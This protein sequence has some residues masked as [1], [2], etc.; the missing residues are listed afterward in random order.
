MPTPLSLFK[1]PRSQCRSCGW[2]GVTAARKRIG[3]FGWTYIVLALLVVPAGVYGVVDLNKIF[4]S[5]VVITIL[6]AL[7]G[8]PYLLGRAEKCPS[9]GGHS[10]EP[11][12]NRSG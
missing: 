5:P 4:T 9:C 2:T 10:L 11:L 3:A 8:I 1:V 12:G 6:I 7:P